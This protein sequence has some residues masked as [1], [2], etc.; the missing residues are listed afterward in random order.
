MA[1][2][3]IANETSRDGRFIAYDN[4]TVLDTS[5]GLMWAAK[6]N[7]SNINWENAKSYC[8]NYHGGGYADWRMPTRD[9]LVGL[10]DASKSRPAGC[11]R[12]LKIHV[13]TD[14]VNITCW[15][16]WASETH[17]WGPVFGPAHAFFNFLT[18]K[19]GADPLPSDNNSR[20]LPV[21]SGIKSVHEYEGG[22]QEEE[23]PISESDWITIIRKG[24][25]TPCEATCIDLYKR[26][27]IKEG[28]TFEECLKS[29]C[30]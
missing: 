26:K 23:E 7:G 5:T 25:S 12:S 9:E 30:Q 4:G 10:S 17:D 18:N 27:R 8:E 13:A 15:L 29:F 20:A 3:V 6:D 21:R 1:K 22:I 16:V 11:K 2:Y 24:P 19:W 28:V 14:M